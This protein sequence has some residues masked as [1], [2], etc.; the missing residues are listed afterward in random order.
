MI[1]KRKYE[2]RTAIFR[3]FAAI[4]RFSRIFQKAKSR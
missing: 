3:I 2:A 4:D 1:R